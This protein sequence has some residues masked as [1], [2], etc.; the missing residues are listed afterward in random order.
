MKPQF[1]ITDANAADVATIVATL[2][3]VPLALEL[4]AARLRLLTPAALSER[5]D[6]ALPIL[7]GGARDRPERQRTLRATIDWSA[8]LLSAAERDLLLQLAVFRSGFALDAVEWMCEGVAAADAADLLGALVESSLVQEQ[9]R[10]FGPWFSMLATVR[11]YARDELERR[12]DL[13]TQLQRHADFYSELAV[14]AEPELLG[15]GQ[16]AWLARLRDEFEDIR[17]AVDHYLATGQR[18]AVAQLVWPLYWFWWIT[19]RI[20]EVGDWVASL[21]EAGDE[22]SEQTRARATFYVAGLATWKKTDPSRIPDLENC[23][24]YFVRQHDLFGEF[25]VR[26]DLAIFELF[27]GS[28]GVEAADHQLH[29]AQIIADEI[30]SPSLAAMVLLIRGQAYSARGDVPRARETFEASLDAAKSIGEVVLQYSALYQLGWVQMRLGNQGA[31]REFFIEELLM[32]SAVGHE[33]GIAYGLEGLFAV[34]ATVG[35]VKQAGRLLGA[36]EDIR[37]RKGLLGP[38]WFSYHQQIL[39][40]LEA[41]PAADEFTIAR[42]EGHRADIAEVVQEALT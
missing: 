22:V 13:Q 10:G 26:M 12:G 32:S 24:T 7:V 30:Q 41:S 4:A 6:R 2:D 1:K 28:S 27:R 21:A 11:E 3:N 37:A 38:G 17:G 34:A 14:R 20:P 16:A 15:S 5:L 39:E 35:D 40:Q 36:A 25:L 8:R 33:E 23:L 42:E 29:R 31:A 19:G 18:D 9:D